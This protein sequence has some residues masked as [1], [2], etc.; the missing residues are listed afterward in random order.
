M[1]R[2]LGCACAT[3]INRT[4]SLHCF[5]ISNAL[6]IDHCVFNFHFPHI[7][8]WKTRRYFHR[9]ECFPPQLR[10]RWHGYCKITN[11]HFFT[12]IGNNSWNESNSFYILIGV[13]STHGDYYS[14]HHLYSTFDNLIF[15]AIYCP[16]FLF[17]V[18]QIQSQ[19][20]LACS[21]E[22]FK[23]H[24]CKFEINW[25]TVSMYVPNLY[26]LRNIYTF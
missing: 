18:V 22:T 26:I 3:S 8:L 11:W 16:Y 14:F 21:F 23:L 10:S 12:F 17:C 13:V 24:R 4:P 5:V 19:Q 7:L 6:F 20:Y 1:P 9:T 25:L 2:K 15:F